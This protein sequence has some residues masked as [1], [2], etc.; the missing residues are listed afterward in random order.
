MDRLSNGTK[1]AW[2][3]IT[4]TNPRQTPA[5]NIHVKVTKFGD[6][7]WSFSYGVEHLIPDLSRAEGGGGESAGHEA[8]GDPVATQR[9]GGADGWCSLGVLAL[10]TI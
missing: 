7:E 5:A 6:K 4:R 9:W 8:Q 10:G 3:Q 2:Q 1:L